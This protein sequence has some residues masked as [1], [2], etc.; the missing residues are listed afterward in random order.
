M[1]KII[2]IL[3]LTLSFGAAVHAET[4][5]ELKAAVVEARDSL[6]IMVKNKDKRTPEHQ[7]LVKDSAD[8]VS[9]ML[10]KVTVGADKAKAMDEFKTTWTEFKKTRETELVPAILAGKQEEGD[11]LA[12]GIQKERYKKMM[13]LLGQIEK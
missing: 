10:G 5:A 6:V 9:S 7:K 4:V 1:K 2:T 3:A 13:D 8:K 11:K 12:T